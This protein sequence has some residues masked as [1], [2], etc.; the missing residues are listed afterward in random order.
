MEETGLAELDTR[1]ILMGLYSFAWAAIT[2]YHRL[3]GLISEIYFLTVLGA[4]SRDQGP[5]KLGS[6][7]NSLPGL[8]TAD[9]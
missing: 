9:F 2:K 5:A 7:E 8:K 4:R 3:D 6:D 1:S